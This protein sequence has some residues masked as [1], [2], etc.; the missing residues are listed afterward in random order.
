MS[1][2]YASDAI[3]LDDIPSGEGDAMLVLYTREYG[4]VD[5][6]ARGIR[7]EKSKLRSHVMPMSYT[8]VI[9]VSTKS[10]YLLTDANV[11]TLPTAD[12]AIYARREF[13]RFVASMLRE[14]ERDPVMWGFLYERLIE[15]VTPMDRGTLLARKAEMLA[16]MGLLPEEGIHSEDDITRILAL[17]HLVY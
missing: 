4:K 1:N 17:N 6:L 14:P 3:V 2:Y 7:W 9:M 11:Y 5:V 10:S 8:R 12:D 15:R 13:A 16:L